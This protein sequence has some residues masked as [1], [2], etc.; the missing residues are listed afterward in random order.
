MSVVIDV[1]VIKNHLPE[2]NYFV[3]VNKDS[4]DEDMFEYLTRTSL[5]QESYIQDFL[6]SDT[7]NAL[8]TVNNWVQILAVQNHP[9][10]AY[11][12][13]GQVA[14]YNTATEDLQWTNELIV[15]SAEDVTLIPIDYF[16]SD[17]ENTQFLLN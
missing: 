8:T 9:K 4:F 5:A 11:C 7:W 15:K 17:A 12:V 14:F 2:G 13:Q 1:E 3:I 10:D 16:L 6:P